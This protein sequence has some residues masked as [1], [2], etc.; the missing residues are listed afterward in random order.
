MRRKQ[1][2][3]KTLVYLLAGC[4]SLGMTQLPVH[5]AAAEGLSADTGAAGSGTTVD[6]GTD[7]TGDTGAG[8]TGDTGTGDTGNT[9]TEEGNGNAGQTDPKKLADGTYALGIQILKSSTKTQSM[10]AKAYDPTATLVVKDGTYTLH[11]NIVGM[12]MGKSMIYPGTFDM[13]QTGY[14]ADTAGKFTGETKAAAIASYQTNADGSTYSDD[15]ADKYPKEISFTVI[16]EALSDS[17]IPFQVTIPF[18]AA[19]GAQDSYFQLDWTSIKTVQTDEETTEASGTNEEPTGEPGEATGTGKD[20]QETDTPGTTED[21]QETGTSGTEADGQETGTSGTE[22]D[23]QETGTSGTDIHQTDETGSQKGTKSTPESTAGST[24]PLDYKQLANGTYTLSTQMLKVDKQTISMADGALHHT[25]TLTVKDGKYEL[26][27]DF[28]GLAVGTQFGYLGTLRAYDAKYGTDAN[29]E[30]TGKMT[31]AK[32]DAYQTN[33]DGT[34]LSDRYAD[35]YPKQVTFG[36]IPEAITDGLVPIQVTVP[37]M[38]QMVAGAGTHNAYLKLDWSTLKEGA[39][40]ETGKEETGSSATG[41][42][43]SEDGGNAANLTAG[44]TAGNT[45][46][47]TAANPALKPAALPESAGDG[48]AKGNS[49]LNS[50]GGSATGSSLGKDAGVDGF[51]GSAIGG[52]LGGSTTGST[53]SGQ[54]L[55]KKTGSLS[56]NTGTKLG[57]VKKAASVDTSDRTGLYELESLGAIAV[58]AGVLLMVMK[59]RR[60]E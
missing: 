50:L 21:G 17:L 45:P 8:A 23:E 3:K 2:W 12:Q 53:L 22:E 35:R 34:L 30:P 6:T 47:K 56:G 1:F 32:V 20:G 48:L 19:L 37:L 41:K 40:A 39:Q 13:Y 4:M 24:K 15:K 51:G 11:V 58:F 38:E 5:A 7:A 49:F 26:T 10:S 25:V 33:A 55:G 44:N 54:T 16:P 14:S 52:S 31:E 57:T 18:M 60:N 29:G 9:S 28:D 27:L 59:K 36:L 42:T 43:G 46:G